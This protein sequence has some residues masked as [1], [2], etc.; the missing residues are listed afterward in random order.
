MIKE[1]SGKRTTHHFNKMEADHVARTVVNRRIGSTLRVNESGKAFKC[2]ARQSSVAGS[3]RQN[4]LLI[5]FIGL[6]AVLAVFSAARVSQAQVITPFT[7]RFSINSRGDVVLT[8]NTLMTCPVGV[9]TCNANGAGNNNS[10]SMGYVNSDTDL[11]TFNSSSAGVNLPAGAEVLFAGLYWGADTSAGNMGGAP[12][13]NAAASLQISFDT[14]A[15]GSYQTINGALIG[16]GGSTRYH[17]FYDATSLVQAAGNGTYTVANVQ[18]GTGGDR[19]AGWSLV[20]AYRLASAELRNLTV[21]DGYASVSSGN[22]NV[23]FT[24]SGFLTPPSGP[25]VTRLGTVVYE[26]DRESSGDNL[27]LNGAILSNSLNPSNNYFNSTITD[28]GVPITDKTPNFTNQLGFDIDR[29]EAP[30]VIANSATSATINLTTGGETYFPGVVT[31]TTDLYLPNIP[32]TK[33][34]VDING[35]A[36]LPGD[37]IEY[38]IP[39][40]NTGNDTANG[41]VLTDVLPSN[42]T[43]VPNSIS[44]FSGANSG[45]KTDAADGD[46]AEFLT[47][48]A[49]VV[50]RPGA[51]AAGPGITG[52]LGVSESNELRFRVQVNAGTNNQQVINQASITY[53]GVTSEFVTNEN[54]PP[55]VLQIPNPNA[56]L[57]ITKTNGSTTLTVGATTTYS[58][59][60]TNNG[61]DTATGAIIRDNFPIGLTNVT[62]S[63]TPSPGASCGATN[64]TGNIN[65]TVTLPLNGTATFNATGTVVS[66]A[67]GSITNTATVTPAAGTGDSNPNNNLATD[68]DTVSP[69]ASLSITKTNNQV[70]VIRGQP[71]SY[72]IVVTNGGPAAANGAPVIDQ[73]PAG[74]LDATWTCVATGGAACGA[75]SGT[76]DINTTVNLPPNGTATFTLTATVSATAASPLANS[77]TVTPP[78]GVTDNNVG[79]NTATDT[80]TVVGPTAASVTV[81]GRVTT[82][83]GR[84]ISG[85]RLSMTDVNGQVRYALTNSFGYYRFTGVVPGQTYIFQVR[86]KEYVFTPQVINVTADIANLNFAAQPLDDDQPNAP[87]TRSA[88]LRR[89]K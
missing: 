5:L 82:N 60:V 71:T 73:I 10:Y 72:T 38:R 48:P 24:V 46:Q 52:T 45:T 1:I 63:C 42:T 41:I 47:G 61:P 30:Q 4:L 51:G 37:I 27:R 79:N 8:G 7:P 84:G 70:A 62:W 88:R 74:L 44:V 86:N 11:T 35:G 69:V 59:V 54:G 65:T 89:E 23:S 39:L 78:A 76:G 83:E 67:N 80:D 25:V 20:I 19:Y 13:P 64:G 36:L 6:A 53:T 85:T 14:P 9:G 29:A 32:V 49:R 28:L 50:Y 3:G 21:F 68:T 33:S 87:R 15:A 77:A 40:Q 75:A 56:D 16:V 55:V 2:G 58:I 17:A 12:A 81:A 26:G 22:P 18:A 43:F 34:A 31:F 57:T 66:T